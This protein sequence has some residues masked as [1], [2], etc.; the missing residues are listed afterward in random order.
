MR[1]LRR[2]SGQAK[3]NLQN[4]CSPRR[5]GDHGH[6]V[7]SVRGHIRSTGAVL[8]PTRASQGSSQSGRQRR[9]HDPENEWWT[10]MVFVV[11]V[12]VVVAGSALVL[13][14]VVLVASAAGRGRDRAETVHTRLVSARPGPQEACGAATTQ[15]VSSNPGGSGGGGNDH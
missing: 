5:L 14:V 3:E 2:V 4:R 11:A 1:Y 13:I 10:K 6:T 8:V 9:S 12:V 15:H 7:R